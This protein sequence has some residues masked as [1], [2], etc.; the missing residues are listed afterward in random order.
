MISIG[1]PAQ[2]ASASTFVDY[3]TKVI[4]GRTP[5]KALVKPVSS[6]AVI[7]S[8]KAVLNSI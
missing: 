7:N 1:L 6:K 4:R 5:K 3:T 8:T 2:V